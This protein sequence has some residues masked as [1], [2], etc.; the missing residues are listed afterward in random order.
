VS[1]LSISKEAGE[2][3]Q[4]HAAL[5]SPLS[6]TTVVPPRHTSVV[7]TLPSDGAG[8]SGNGVPAWQLAALHVSAPLHASP[9][10][11][12][13]PSA[14]LLARHVPDPLQVSGLSQDESDELPQLKP[15]VRLPQVPFT[16][17]PA[18][19]LQA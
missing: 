7:Q 13:V 8:P 17:A 4:A 16:A 11:Q 14:S 12:D 1:K 9:S 2:Q 15:A 10:E 3:V 6:V 18:A 5:V 19:V